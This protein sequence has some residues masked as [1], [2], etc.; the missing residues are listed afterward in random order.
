MRAR[1]ISLLAL[2]FLAIAQPEAAN[3]QFS[4]RGVLG[5]VTAPFREML[6]HL[7]H[8]PP[9]HS[10]RGASRQEQAPA[11]LPSQLGLVGPLAWP[12]AYEEILG[13]TF[14]PGEYAVQFR[15]HGFDVIADTVVGRFNVPPLRGR[16]SARTSTNGAAVS[17]SS[18]EGLCDIGSG[19]QAD[20]PATRIEQTAQLTAAQRDA[21]NR[22]KTAIADSTKALKA[23]CRDVTSLPPTGRLKVMVQRLWAVRDAGIFVRE[24][25]K[26]FTES[27]SDA[28]KANFMFEIPQKE[29][30]GGARNADSG[31]G[32]YQAC[33]S[34]IGE[35]AERMVRQI[36]RTVRPDKSQ[37][38]GLEALR[39]TSSE[40]ARMLSASCAQPIPADPLARLDAANNQ[41]S[42]MSFAAT[43]L[44]IA[45]NGF[46]TGLD[47]DQKKRFDALD[48]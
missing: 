41:L 5:A 29:P 15:M 36:E 28:Q 17:D 26:T 19:A 11:P 43:N 6:G 8:F 3:A 35:D 33:A 47:Q 31:M 16:E 38:A 40:M 2:M 32:R 14:W 48:R 39:K 46:Y 30:R 44:G 25:L 37:R 34:Q 13:Y 10:R 12:S 23:G 21:F 20:W 7:R 4:P 9:R 1:T 42:S 24:P 45:L 18:G 22:L 27:L